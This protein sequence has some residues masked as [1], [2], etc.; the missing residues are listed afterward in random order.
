[1]PY[2]GVFGVELK[3]NLCEIWNHHP[4]ICLIAKY[5]E[6][7][8]IPKFGTKSALFG[9]FLA[10][11]LKNYCHNWNQHLRIS[12]IVKF[13]EET[14]M[15]KFRNKNALLGIFGQEF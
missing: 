4:W 11:T 8:K 12:V 10:R 13:C 6:I 5:R 9:Y 3:K 2:L 7:M 1:M 14:K 15:L